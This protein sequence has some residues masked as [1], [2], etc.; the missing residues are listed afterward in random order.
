[1]VGFRDSVLIAAAVSLAV[2]A[3]V[4]APEVGFAQSEEGGA[5]SQQ[6]RRTPAM[7]ERVYNVLC[8]AQ[9]CAQT[10]STKDISIYESSSSVFE[11]AALD[12]AAKFKYKPRVIDGEPVE[13]PGVRNRIT[14]VLEK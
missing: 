3:S 9:A 13:V 5:S 6:T 12:A 2:A 10:G 1:M 8:E 14:F 4:T 7:R 11:R